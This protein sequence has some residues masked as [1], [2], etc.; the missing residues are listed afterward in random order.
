VRPFPGQGNIFQFESTGRFDQQQLIFSFNTR[1]S[2]LFTLRTNYVLN[3]A[4]GDTEGLGTFPVNQYDLSGEY[5]RSSQDVRHRLSLFGTINALPWGIRLNPMVTIN[6]GRPFNITTG[7]DTNGDTLFNERPAF[8]DQQTNAADLRQTIYGDFDINPKPGQI[9]IPRNYGTSSSFFVVNLRI[10]KTFGFGGISS[11]QNAGGRQNGGGGRRG[12]GGGRRGGGSDSGDGQTNKRFNLNLSV[13][14]QN[15]FN[16]TNE[17]LPIGNL[18]SPL[19]GVSTS[20]AGGFGRR[21]GNQGGGNQGAGNRRIEL[22]ARF[23]F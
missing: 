17:S 8:A 10:G 16:N 6:S 2:Q 4:K 21:G 3:R 5:G 1:F 15:L 22:Q 18:S 9:I 7:R 23:N 13:N 19:F 14:I 12:G 11:V 20:T